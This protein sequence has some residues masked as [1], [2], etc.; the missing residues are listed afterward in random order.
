MKAL[1]ILM[2]KNF[3]DEE[4]RIP[5]EKLEGSGVDVTVAGLQW[6]TAKGMLGMTATPDILLGEVD[7]DDYDVIVVPGGSGS[8]RYL[9]NNPQAHGLIRKAY[10]RGKIVASICLSSVVLANAGVLEGRDATVFA[11]PVSVRILEDRGANYLQQ[12]VVVDGKIVTAD[13]PQ[14]AGRFADEIL[15]LLAGK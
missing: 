3:R 8:P 7:I 4:F 12:E 2:P 14:S 5:K 10:D 9:W 6:G 13:G 1:I 11:T 15:R